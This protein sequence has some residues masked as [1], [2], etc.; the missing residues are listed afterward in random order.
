MLELLSETN[1]PIGRILCLGAHCDDVEIGCGGTVLKL[2]E[3]RPD[4]HVDWIVFTS[5]EK[6]AAEAYA[7]AAPRLKAPAETNVVH[8]D[9]RQR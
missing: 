4:V 2:L 1:A 5:D 7:G 3:A 6:R 8:P 9:V